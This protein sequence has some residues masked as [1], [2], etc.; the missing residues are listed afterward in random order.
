MGDVVHVYSNGTNSQS[1]SCAMYTS[2]RQETTGGWCQ[3]S[4]IENKNKYRYKWKHKKKHTD[5][6]YACMPTTTPLGGKMFSSEET[7]SSV[8]VQVN[9]TPNQGYHTTTVMNTS[10]YTIQVPPTENGWLTWLNGAVVTFSNS[11]IM[12]KFQYTKWYA[13]K[14]IHKPTN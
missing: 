13:K 14:G 4:V 11:K 12:F 10:I 6:I 2:L 5:T 3:A 1:K 9:S 8:Q 7:I